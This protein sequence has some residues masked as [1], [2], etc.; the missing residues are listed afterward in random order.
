MHPKAR[1]FLAVYSGDFPI[2]FT[3]SVQVQAF[4]STFETQLSPYLTKLCDYLFSSSN[5]LTYIVTTF[6]FH[7]ANIWAQTVAR[8]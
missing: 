7:G 4:N 5:Y 8:N 1:G 6:T 2:K 3:E